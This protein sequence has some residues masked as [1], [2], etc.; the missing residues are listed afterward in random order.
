ME[1]GELE[2]V[3]LYG[4][5][6]RAQLYLKDRAMRTAKIAAEI[7]KSVAVTARRGRVPLSPG[8]E[9]LHANRW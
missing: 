9:D 5:G 6:V 2:S 3:L 8:S 4:A 7:V 1:T